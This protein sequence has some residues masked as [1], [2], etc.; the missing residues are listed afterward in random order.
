M[1]RETL[2]YARPEGRSSI[3]WRGWAAITLIL[4]VPVCTSII[5]VAG[6]PFMALPAALGSLIAYVEA[7]RPSQSSAPR[8]RLWVIVAV[9]LVTVVLELLGRI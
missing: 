9:G 1:K 3:S 6:G 2:N 5:L 7:R 4:F 8:G